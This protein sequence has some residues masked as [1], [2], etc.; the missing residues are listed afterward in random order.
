VDQPEQAVQE[1]LRFVGN[2]KTPTITDLKLDLGAGLDQVFSSAAGKVS[3]GQEVTLL[4]RTHH[5]LP[6]SVKVSGNFAGKPFSKSHRLSAKSGRDYAYVPTLW[7]RRYLQNLMGADLHKNRGVIIRLGTDYA[8]MT[9]FTSFLVLESEDQYNRMGIKRRVRDPI[10]GLVPQAALTLPDGLHDGL[11]DGVEAV[12]AAPG[13]LFGCDAKRM[14]SEA[15]QEK[16]AQ[17]PS[18]PKVKLDTADDPLGGLRADGD[19]GGKGK[20]LRE[21]LYGLKGPKDNPDPHM[22][23]LLAQDAAKNAGVLGVF[24][25]TQSSHIASIFGRD[26]A[27]GR[28]ATNAL[29]NLIGSELQEAYG[30]VGGL[31]LVGP[32]KGGG[33]TGEG[34]YGVGNL[35]TIGKCVGNACGPGSNSGYWNHGPGIDRFKRHG[36]GPEVT[37]GIVKTRG[38]LDKEIIRRVIRSHL[39][40][41]KFCYESELVK[42]PDLYGRLTV[43]FTI[44]PTGTVSSSAVEQS[45]VGNRN[46]EQCIAAAVKRWTFPQP[47]DGGIVLVN[48]PFVLQAPAGK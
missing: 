42:K 29:G 30:V 3:R 7:A 34:T 35:G 25:Q 2:L 22:A 27:L 45:S 4:A 13:A 39:K 5:P 10:W 16:P 32:G 18:S 1:A 48:Y 14:L 43:Q 44:T 26:S 6:D 36:T 28:D 23:K 20:R 46:V 24:R 41:V 31:G 8:L 17:A 12:A 21:G 38:R 40:E 11:A 9:P 47:E 15:P 33:G 19:M 37:G